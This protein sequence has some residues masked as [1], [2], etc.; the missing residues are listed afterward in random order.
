MAYYKSKS[1]SEKKSVILKFHLRLVYLQFAVKKIYIYIHMHS[2]NI[3]STF[4]TR[5][6]LCSILNTDL[7]VNVRTRR[8]Y[9]VVKLSPTSQFFKLW[10]FCFHYCIV[11]YLT[12]FSRTFSLIFTIHIFCS[13]HRI[14]QWTLSFL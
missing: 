5:L 7:I 9:M 2:V 6:L 4:S 14:L 13:L 10:S 12:Q 3:L 1:I 11:F 8:L